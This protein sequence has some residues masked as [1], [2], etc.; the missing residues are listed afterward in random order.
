MTLLTLL[1]CAGKGAST[2]DS[3]PS[4]H[5][6]ADSSTETGDDTGQTPVDADSDGIPSTATGGADCDDTDPF[7]H[8][9]AMDWCDGKDQDCDGDPIGEG[10][11]TVSTDTSALDG[12]RWWPEEPF[13]EHFLFEAIW[14]TSG[15]DA[16][17][18]AVVREQNGTW[19]EGV[20]AYQ[21]VEP[22]RQPAGGAW[23]DCTIDYYCARGITD[24]GDFD[25]DGFG[26]LLMG[27]PDWG[28][29]TAAVFLLSGD[30]ST[31]PAPGT[32]IPD[33]AAASWVQLRDGDDFATSMAG[34]ADVNADGLSDFIV[35]A[36]ENNDEGDY[37]GT[38]HLM[39]GRTGSMPTLENAGEE[40]TFHHQANG[41]VTLD[42]DFYQFT[43]ARDLDGDGCD[44][45]LARGYAGE[46]MGGADLFWASGAALPGLDGADL[47]DVFDQGLWTGYS[48]H[49][50]GGSIGDLDGDG[51]A[52]LVGS[53][54]NETDG[55][56]IAVLSGAAIAA[57]DDPVIA[58]VTGDAQVDLNAVSDDL[59]GDGLLD[60]IVW[61]ATDADEGRICALPTTFLHVGGVTLAEE[62]GPC[63]E[64][65][66]PLLADLDHDG[67][68]E[69]H[70]AQD[71]ADEDGE[72][73]VEVLSLPQ[74]DIPW[75][76]PTKW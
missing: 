35:W 19:P 36:P 3:P 21:S 76:D 75:E 46:E 5:S 34:N 48:L 67:A 31:W 49:Q 25:G 10:M 2:E 4:G 30:T 8:P 16:L 59:D 27:G 57:G 15:G 9:G 29:R 60:P 28:V 56:V 52:D 17:V 39:L 26:E 53:E 13:D 40:I 47:V 23:W 45:L 6:G 18:A 51:I 73:R 11:C 61:A 20:L 70:F 41:R 44:D 66:S 43:T 38:L 24:I 68:P 54:F 33:A 58:A 72:Y 50:Q 69:F 32:P 1:G 74:F 7:T 64:S 42:D 37:Q 62:I 14:H 71:G 65:Y 12:V 55:V 22:G 63:F